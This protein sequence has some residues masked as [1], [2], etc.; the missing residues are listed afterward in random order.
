MENYRTTEHVRH[1]DIYVPGFL[2]YTL[3]RW[4]EV[5][6]IENSHMIDPN[7]QFL[8]FEGNYVKMEGMGVYRLRMLNTPNS[9]LPTL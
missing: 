7:S 5:S 1:D 4:M 8:S 3:S 2:N 9:L 6:N